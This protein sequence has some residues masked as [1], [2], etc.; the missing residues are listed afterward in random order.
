MNL[1]NI[2]H[3]RED[4]SLRCGKIARIYSGVNTGTTCTNRTL[5]LTNKYEFT[6]KSL[7]FFSFQASN[8]HLNGILLNSIF[9]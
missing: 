3:K 9:F 6:N 8:L 4:H 7:Q 1:Q 5:V 2:D